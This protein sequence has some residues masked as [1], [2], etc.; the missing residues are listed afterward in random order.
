[1]TDLVM[2]QEGRTRR[3]DSSRLADFP[4]TLQQWSGPAPMTA[5]ARSM[6]GQRQRN[7]LQARFTVDRS[8]GS[9][10]LAAAHGEYLDFANT[11]LYR[12][13]RV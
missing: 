13:D 12:V 8:G 5:T 9:N 3:T 6:S 7:I 10:G 4:N 11:L 2:F 1:M